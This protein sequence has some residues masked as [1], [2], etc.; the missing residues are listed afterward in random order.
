MQILLLLSWIQ[1]S[2]HLEFKCTLLVVVHLIILNKICNY[3]ILCVVKIEIIYK[4]CLSVPNIS[5]CFK[6]SA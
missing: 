1:A 6:K 5:L 2:G 4:V 3:N